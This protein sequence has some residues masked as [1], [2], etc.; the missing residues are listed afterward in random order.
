MQLLHVMLQG[1][2]FTQSSQSTLLLL[3]SCPER[4]NLTETVELGVLVP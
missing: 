1:S 2:G 3:A 4:A